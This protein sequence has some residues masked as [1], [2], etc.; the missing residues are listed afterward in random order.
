VCTFNIKESKDRAKDI[1]RNE[2]ELVLIEGQ[3]KL[4][5]YKQVNDDQ[6]VIGWLFTPSEEKNSIL[7]D[8]DL[9]D[10]FSKI[11]EAVCIFESQSR[12]GGGKLEVFGQRHIIYI[13]DSNMISHIKDRWYFDDRVLD[14]RGY[15]L[16]A[17]CLAVD[18][19]RK[20]FN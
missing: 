6:K 12:W 5:R 18:R 20:A 17:S 11:L 9:Y 7:L 15:I 8:K 16:E 1:Y 2:N 10:I 3:Q 4:I 13:S 19:I 14:F